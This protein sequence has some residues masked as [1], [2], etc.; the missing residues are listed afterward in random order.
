VTRRPAGQKHAKRCTLYRLTGSFVH[1]DKAGR[2][3]FYFTGRIR[4]KMLKPG[5]YPP[6]GD[7]DVRGAE[8]RR[9]HRRLPS[10]AVGPGET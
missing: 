2:N 9:A 7:P 8:R 5:V 10:R 3:S 1:T 4:G 6:Q